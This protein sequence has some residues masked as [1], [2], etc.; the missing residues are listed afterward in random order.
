MRWMR[1]FKGQGVCLTVVRIIIAYACVC[2]SVC[3]C[4]GSMRMLQGMELRCYCL[5]ELVVLSVLL[6][7]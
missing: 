4:Y 7:R 5:G 1:K 3:M 2:V 6:I